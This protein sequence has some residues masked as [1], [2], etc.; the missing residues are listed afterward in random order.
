[1]AGKPGAE[2]STES[3]P[4][5]RGKPGKLGGCRG[6][7]Q[8]VPLYWGVPNFRPGLLPPPR[9]HAEDGKAAPKKFS[10]GVQSWWRSCPVMVLLVTSFISREPQ[11]KRFTR[12]PGGEPFRAGVAHTLINQ[13]VLRDLPFLSFINPEIC[14]LGADRIRLGPRP[15]WLGPGR[16][17]CGASVHHR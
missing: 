8:A 9:P 14:P 1:M 5:K 13:G 15:G 3:L 11:A 6:K 12:R 7:S 2:E 4:P 10:K 17:Q 16:H